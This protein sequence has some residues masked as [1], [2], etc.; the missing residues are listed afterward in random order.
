MRP[1]TCFVLVVT[2]VAGA[3]ARAQIHVDEARIA[4]GDLRISGWTTPRTLIAVDEQFVA[5]T[6]S[7]GRFRFRLPYLPA[8]CIANLKAGSHGRDVVLANC[9][10]RGP[11]RARWTTWSRRT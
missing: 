10:P 9:G 3:P 1:L 2:A 7:R 4:R 11:A 8:D 6:D 5:T